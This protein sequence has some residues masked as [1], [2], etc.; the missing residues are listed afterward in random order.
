MTAAEQCHSALTDSVD[1]VAH[2]TALKE[3]CAGSRVVVAR[4]LERC[5]ERAEINCSLQSRW[6]YFG[7]LAE[8]EYFDAF[9]QDAVDYV[10]S[11]GGLAGQK[12]APIGSSEEARY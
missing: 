9:R 7:V 10:G 1:L 5:A 8:G 2:C 3:D 11:C 12:Q 4:R 6:R